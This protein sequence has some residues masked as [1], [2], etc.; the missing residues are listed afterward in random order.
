MN[1]SSKAACDQAVQVLDFNPYVEA[2]YSPSVRN[3]QAT[4]YGLLLLLLC[5]SSH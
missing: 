3:K 2:V 5:S 4:S 1:V